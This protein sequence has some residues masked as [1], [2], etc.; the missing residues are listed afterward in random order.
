MKKKLIIFLMAC[1][2]SVAT[3]AVKADPTPI[4]ITQ[5]DGTKLTIRLNGD[6]DLHWYSTTDGVLLVQ[7]NMTYYVAKVNADGSLTA[8]TT[9]AHEA[10]LRSET[11]KELIAAQN[12]E[13]FRKQAPIIKQRR[14][15]QRLGNEVNASPATNKRYFPHTGSPK[16]LVLLVEFSDSVFT[17]ANPKASFDEYLNGT[18][19]LAN[20]GN[21]ENRNHGSV[22]EYFT[23]MSGGTFTPQFDVYGP[24]NVAK[25]IKYYGG[26]SSTSGSD[27]NVTGLVKDACTLA[28][29]DVDFSQY[30]SNNDGYVDLVYLIYAGWGQSH[31][32]VPAYNIWPKSG[33]NSFTDKFDGKSLYRYGVS[34]ELNFTP[35]SPNSYPIKRIEGIGLFC[36]EFSHTMGLPDLYAT[37]TAAETDNQAMERWDLMDEGEYLDNGYCP[38]PYTAWEKETMGWETIETLSGAQHVDLQPGESRKIEQ[39]ADNQCV[40]LTNWQPTG[41][42]SGLRYQQVVSTDPVR[43][44]KTQYMHGLLTMRVDYKRVSNGNVTNPTVVNSDDYP[45]NKLGEPGITIVPADGYL[46]TSM[47]VYDKIENKTEYLC[48]SSE[49]YWNSLHGDPFPGLKNVTEL[50]SIQLNKGVTIDDQPLYK[51]TEDPYL[52]EVYSNVAPTYGTGIVSFN[53]I[54]EDIP[55]ALTSV[56]VQKEVLDNRVFSLD[57]R[58]VGTTTTGLSKGIYI[59]GKKKVVIK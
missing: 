50:T 58:Y 42:M 37:V 18:A 34:N 25:S 38:A 26:T 19:P 14:M 23:D 59:I 28:N 7:D 56:K 17:L 48:W 4:T 11:E 1:L 16:V 31:N 21:Y 44:V 29:N 45:N 41:W 57:G 13:T 39:T 53:F 15:I 49:D 43:V 20:H 55:T 10:P 51:I 12:K 3:W 46:I 30:D 27:E 35:T 47:R 24:Y 54:D 22:R 52:D 33:Y 8:T 5:P 32:G 6:E 9:L 36:H 2:T 40:Y